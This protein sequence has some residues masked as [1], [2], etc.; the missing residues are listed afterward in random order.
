MSHCR[1]SSPGT[2]VCEI[3]SVRFHGI[4]FVWANEH[5]SIHNDLI[6]GYD[7]VLSVLAIEG[8]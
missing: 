1:I 6:D 4:G 3:S 5:D 8:F 2:G 7:E